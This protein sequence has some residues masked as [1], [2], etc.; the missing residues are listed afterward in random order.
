M[1]R[2]RDW[3]QDVP[4][5]VFWRADAGDTPAYNR[6]FAHLLRELVPG[7]GA[8]SV[9]SFESGNVPNLSTFQRTVARE[10]RRRRGFE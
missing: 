7:A 6:I 3:I 8:I 1:S 10:A 9:A 2:L 5:T 4:D